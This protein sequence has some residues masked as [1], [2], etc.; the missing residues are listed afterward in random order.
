MNVRERDTQ[1]GGSYAVKKPAKSTLYI[2][3]EHD[4]TRLLVVGM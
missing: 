3:A 2:I 1:F 4:R